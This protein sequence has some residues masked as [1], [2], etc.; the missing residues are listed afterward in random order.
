[1]RM[2]ACL[3][4]G[5]S[6]RMQI[7]IAWVCKIKPFYTAVMAKSLVY[8]SMKYVPNRYR[9]TMIDSHPEK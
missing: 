4:A 8:A 1:M 5:H 6:S 2:F 3:L 7:Y 9:Q